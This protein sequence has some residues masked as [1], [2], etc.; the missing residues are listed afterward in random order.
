MILSS[1]LLTYIIISL[2]TVR[3]PNIKFASAPISVNEDILLVE[4]EVKKLA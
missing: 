4:N 2:V 3:N 1:K